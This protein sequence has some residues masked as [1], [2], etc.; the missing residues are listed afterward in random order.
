MSI[1]ETF[2]KIKA[3]LLPAYW[4]AGGLLS[5][6]AVPVVVLCMCLISFGLGRISAF[7][8]ARAPV[9]IGK[10]PEAAKPREM[11]LGGEIVASRTGSAY[12]FPWCGGATKISAVNKVWFKNEAAARAAG[13][14]PAKNCKGLGSQSVAVE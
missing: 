3:R 6:V 1:P 7:E 8:E 14:A 11:F 5:E 13:Y 4:E 12:Y 9:T 2:R 10:A